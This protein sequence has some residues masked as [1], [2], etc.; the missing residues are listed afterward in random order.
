MKIKT[1]K[2]GIAWFFLI[3][4]LICIPGEDLPKA[5]DWM[6][7]ID[8]DKLVHIGLFAVLG[9]LIM[10]P[11]ANGLLTDKMKW[12]FF[13][14][15]AVAVSIYGITTEFIQRFL[16]PGRSFDIFD[17]LADSIGAVIALLFSRRIYLK[18]NLTRNTG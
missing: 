8:F 17:W 15:V 9:F 12:N 11:A 18:K 2:P 1:Y 14:K 5:D 3:L 10:S 7:A 13:I 6:N 4:I 16:I